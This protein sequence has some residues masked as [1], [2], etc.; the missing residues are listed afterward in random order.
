MHTRMKALLGV[1]FLFFLQTAASEIFSVTRQWPRRTQEV[2]FVNY[3][4][5]CFVFCLYGRGNNERHHWQQCSAYCLSIMSSPPFVEESLVLPCLFLC[6]VLLFRR[7][8]K[9]SKLLELCCVDRDWGD[10]GIGTR[11]AA[12]AAGSPAE[13]QRRGLGCAHT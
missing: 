4:L 8:E 9:N 13:E 11:A 6:V 12:L 3:V 7:A 5:L 10:W 1:L 2:I